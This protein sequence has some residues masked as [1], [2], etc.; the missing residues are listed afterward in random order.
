MQPPRTS[1]P[2]IL[3][4]YRIN[5]IRIECDQVLCSPP[6]ATLN[7]NIT[8]VSTLT[9]RSIDPYI[10][11]QSV[12]DVFFVS[13][14]MPY[15]FCGIYIT[16]GRRITSLP[17]LSINNS[18]GR[19][20]SL[21]RICCCEKGNRNGGG[22]GGVSTTQPIELTAD[23][24][25]NVLSSQSLDTTVVFGAHLSTTRLLHQSHLSWVGSVLY[26]SCTTP[27]DGRLRSR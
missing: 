12:T 7:E 21:L 9:L 25:V 24:F 16:R 18:I 20:Y 4:F 19:T 13:V 22:G 26:K 27:H 11:T 17:R 5:D 1:I 15:H 14:P 23:V 3:S 8:T 2:S 6:Y 10:R